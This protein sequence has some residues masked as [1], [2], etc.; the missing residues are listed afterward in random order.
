VLR[1][2]EPGMKRPFRVPGGLAGAVLLAV[3][4]TLL[5]GAAVA[6]NVGEQGLTSGL[7]IGLALVAAG[8]MVY[9]LM[10]Q[11]AS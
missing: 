3:L 6:R 10:R 7:L 1:V 4:P 2:R 9:V 5:L 11:Q 8:P